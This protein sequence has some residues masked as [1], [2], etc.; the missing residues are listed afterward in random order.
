MRSLLFVALLG[1]L[2]AGEGFLLC[3]SGVYR[4][5]KVRFSCFYQGIVY[6]RGESLCLFM[7]LIRS[8]L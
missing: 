8:F 7:Q 6:L 2:Q 3:L 5:T 1:L 4:H